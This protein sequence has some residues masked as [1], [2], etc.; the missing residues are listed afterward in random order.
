MKKQ[1]LILKQYT[2]LGILGVVLIGGGAGGVILYK[3]RKKR[4]EKEKELEVK[5]TELRYS[6]KV[7][8]KVA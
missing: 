5:N 2:V 8:D 6:K 4:L 3:R 7:H 1:N